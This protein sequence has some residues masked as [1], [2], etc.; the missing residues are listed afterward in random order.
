MWIL[1]RCDDLDANAAETP[2]LF[3]D[4]LAKAPVLACAL[5]YERCDDAFSCALRAISSAIVTRDALP[6]KPVFA[7]GPPFFE[8]AA[9]APR[10]AA[11]SE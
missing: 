3:C 11:A 4:L 2:V 5:S 8:A 1:L 6:P 10:E 7:P 9:K